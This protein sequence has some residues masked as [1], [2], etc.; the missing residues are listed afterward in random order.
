ME[1]ILKNVTYCPVCEDIT[2]RDNEEC[3]IISVRGYY[4]NVKDA[5]VGRPIQHYDGRV[6]NV[7]H[8]DLYGDGSRF[9]LKV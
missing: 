6:C 5:K 9:V 2:Y 1:L 7:Y 3:L 8:G 4:V